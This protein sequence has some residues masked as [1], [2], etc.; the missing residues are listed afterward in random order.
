VHPAIVWVVIDVT[1]LAIMSNKRLEIRKDG[2]FVFFFVVQLLHKDFA[3][4][5]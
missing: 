4:F 3:V 1:S 5:S 2:N